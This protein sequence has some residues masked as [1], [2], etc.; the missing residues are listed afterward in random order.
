MADQPEDLYSDSGSEPNPAPDESKVEG[1]GEDEG[2]RE[3]QGETTALL[4]K[5][6]LAGKHFDVGDSV[7][8]KITGI[9]DSDVMV[10]YDTSGTKDESKSKPDMASTA[11]DSDYD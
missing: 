6:I 9:H 1:D 7:V 5:S 11:S 10:E 4:P 3:D 8:L 2:N